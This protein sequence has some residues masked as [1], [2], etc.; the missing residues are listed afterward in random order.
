MRTRFGS[1]GNLRYSQICSLVTLFYQ[2]QIKIF[3]HYGVL[4]DPLNLF[5]VNKMSE[6]Y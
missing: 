6:L 2:N 3:A 4:G 1:S 5:N